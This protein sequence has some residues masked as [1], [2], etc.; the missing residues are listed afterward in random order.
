M[1]TTS[2]VSS[3]TGLAESETT[4][5]RYHPALVSLHWIVAILIFATVLFAGEEGE[6]GRAI[7]IGGF[8]PIG[9]HMILGISTL[10]LLTIRL[11][12]RW[13]TKHPNWASTGTPFLDLVGK[14]THLGLY[15]FTFSI[16]I[17]G[18][19]MASQ[20]GLFARVLGIG[21][22]A[23]RSFGRRGF[24]GFAIGAFHGLSWSLLFLLIL[25]HIGAA[26]YHQFFKKDNLLG[27]MWY[28]KQAE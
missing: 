6:G 7:S 17:T 8:P 5:K 23:A 21:T 24:G 14:L 9:I 25:L 12:V 11:L 3:T 20:R 2:M 19:I 26:L 16:T 10:V 27:R 18:I 28:G 13:F 4:V 22:A 1:T 15:F